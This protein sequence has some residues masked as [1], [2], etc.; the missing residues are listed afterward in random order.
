MH[1]LVVED[2]P[3]VATVLESGLRVAGHRVSMAPSK[4]VALNHT[5]DASIELAII[6]VGLPDGS[7]LDLCAELRRDGF[8]FPVIILTARDEV[9]DR[10][11]GLDAGADDYIGKPFAMVE[12]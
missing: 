8:A 5:T 7:G 1:V 6:D 3:R 11:S 12:L 10:V 9:G 2:S 4:A